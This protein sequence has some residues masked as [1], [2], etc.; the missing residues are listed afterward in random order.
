VEA[1]VLGEL[2]ALD[3]HQHYT[4]YPRAMDMR[5]SLV[6]AHHALEQAAVFVGDTER[7]SLAMT[8]SSLSRRHAHDQG[9]PHGHHSDE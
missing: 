4:Q 8:V 5:R 3:S 9:E 2:R 6:W 1:G 7:G